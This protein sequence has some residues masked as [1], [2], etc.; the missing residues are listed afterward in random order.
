MIANFTKPENFCLPKETLKIFEF[1]TIIN[2]G[3]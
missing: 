2:Y 3:T 1:Y